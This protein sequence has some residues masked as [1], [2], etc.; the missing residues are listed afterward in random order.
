MPNASS[1]HATGTC[2]KGQSTIR[3]SW[4]KY[5]YLEATFVTFKSAKLGDVKGHWKAQNL[6]LFVQVANNSAFVDGNTTRE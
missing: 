2:E 6:T 3:I 1:A 5:Y 4:E